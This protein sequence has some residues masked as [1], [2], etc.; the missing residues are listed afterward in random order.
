MI[1][2]RTRIQNGQITRY[3]FCQ[4]IL[5]FSAHIYN[6]DGKSTPGDVLSLRLLTKCQLS[7]PNVQMTL[8]IKIF[9]H[10]NVTNLS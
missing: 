3:I 2:K 9:Y 7:R 5:L 1:D 6:M 10:Q 8:N 4:P